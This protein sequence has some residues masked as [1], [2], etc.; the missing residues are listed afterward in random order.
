M[1]GT[2]LASLASRRSTQAK[3]Y[4]SDASPKA[5]NWGGMTNYTKSTLVVKGSNNGISSSGSGQHLM[6]AVSEA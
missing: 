6:A 2:F 5:L 1:P 4:Q 3:F